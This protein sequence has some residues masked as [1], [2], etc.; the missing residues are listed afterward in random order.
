MRSVLLNNGIILMSTVKCITLGEGGK[1]LFEYND[2]TGSEV[3]F[4]AEP[5]AKAGLI[6]IAQAFM[7]SRETIE[8][9]ADIAVD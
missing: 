5:Q 1:L 6:A 9:E 3:V 2:G 4:T 7:D 8:L